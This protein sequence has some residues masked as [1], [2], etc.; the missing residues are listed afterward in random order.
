MERYDVVVIGS[1]ALGASSAFH[2]ARAG[3]RVALVDKAEIGSQT[4]PR[5]AGMSGQLRR[6]PVMIDL[7]RRSVEKFVGFTEETGEPMVV[8]QPGSLSVAR[9]PRHAA[10][11]A[12]AAERA[13]AFGLD[14]EIVSVEE[15]HEL[16]PFLQTEGILAVAHTR[17][18]MYL[19]PEQVALG[20]ARGAERLGA[21][22][23]PNTRLDGIV[24][25]HGRVT[26]VVTERGELYAPVVVDAAGGWLRRVAELA[27]SRAP[28]VPMRHQLMITVPLEGVTTD[29]PSVRII[30]VNVY[31]RPSRGGLMLGGYERSPLTIDARLLPA[32]FRIEQLDLDLE[33]LRQLAEAVHEQFPVFCDVE[34]Q[35]VRG[36]LPTMTLDGEHIV[37]PAP[38][39][40]GLFLVGGCNVGGLS[41]SPALGEQLAAWIVDGQPTADISHMSPDRFASDLTEAELN[42]GAWKHYAMFYEPPRVR[43]PAERRAVAR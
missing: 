15:A 26:R 13:R 20:Y 9:I 19:E 2:L 29:Q 17:T 36:G 1:G 21:T 4:S 42:L 12:T 25:E 5:A 28:L 43:A 33:I 38:G 24:V 16:Q 34:L 11:L 41:I 39:V 6:N 27:G 7:A 35:E 8:H 14:V 23:M 22:L 10:G 32:D 40:E 31:V 37:G 18:D 30:D 3:Q